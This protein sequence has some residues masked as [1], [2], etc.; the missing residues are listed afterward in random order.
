MHIDHQQVT[1]VD[2]RDG[3]PRTYTLRREEQSFRLDAS[4]NDET[5]SILLSA[6]DVRRLRLAL[7]ETPVEPATTPSAEEVPVVASYKFPC[8]TTPA[9]P[10]QT[11]TVSLQTTAR[12]PRRSFPRPVFTETMVYLSGSE[13]WMGFN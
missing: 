11:T 1:T 13:E 2:L 3:K 4:S 9:A 10:E 6:D 7:G 8:V 5:V 12:E